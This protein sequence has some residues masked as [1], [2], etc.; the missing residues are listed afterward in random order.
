MRQCDF[1]TEVDR[2]NRGNLKDYLTA[3]KI[4]ERGLPSFIGAEFDFRTAP[5]IREAVKE[6]AENGLFGFTICTPLYRERVRWWFKEV[7]D[8]EIEDDWIVPAYG[9]IFSF[10]TAIRA[11]TQE[12]DAVVVFYPGYSRYAQAISRN[13]RRVVRCPLRPVNGQYEIDLKK[14]E[15]CIRSSGAKL[16]ALCNPNNPTGTVFPADCL[17][18]IAELSRRFGVIVFSDEIFAEVTFEGHRVVPFGKIAGTDGLGLTC[19]SLGKAFSFT[20]VNHANVV[21]ENQRLREAF[22]RQKYRDHYGSIDPM[23]HAALLAAYTPEGAA[24]V[25]AMT[26]YVWQNYLFIADYL[27]RYVPEI[28]VTRPQGT[29]VLWLDLA[30]LGLKGDELKE[31]LLNEALLD[32]EYADDYGTTGANV[33]MNISTPRRNIRAAFENLRQAVERLRAQRGA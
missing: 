12:G 22:V 31:F 32:V 26:E 7:R 9:T 2:T 14:L 6:A 20:G 29:Y 10:S 24:W 28:R 33:R 18:S 3:D 27:E 4:K 23:L 1:E 25:R 16:L 15:E 17:E 30:G 5:V 8:Y 11:F 13:Q 19:T 21:I